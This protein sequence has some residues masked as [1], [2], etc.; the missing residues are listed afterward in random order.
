M[1]IHSKILAWIVLGY[2]NTTL[3][4]YTSTQFSINIKKILD[5]RMHNS[6]FGLFALQDKF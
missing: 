5:G 2:L 6:S 3:S 4:L 1:H